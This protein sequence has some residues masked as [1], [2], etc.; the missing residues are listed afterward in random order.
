MRCAII[1]IGSNTVK[2]NVY[3]VT[4]PDNIKPVLSES[5]TLGLIGYIVG[6]ALSGPGVETLCKTVSDYLRLASD[7]A[8]DELRCVATASLRS[9]DNADEV[10]AELK[11]RSGCEVELISGENEAL[12]GLEGIK[13]NLGDEVRSG[14]MVDMGGGSTELVG[15]IDGRAVRAVSEPFGSLSLF[16][17]FVSGVLPE[18]SELRQLRSFVDSRMDGYDWLKNYGA[19]LYLVGGTGRLIGRLHYELIVR[20]SAATDVATD[21]TTGVTTDAASDAVPHAAPGTTVDAPTEYRSGYTFS[22]KELKALYGRFEKPS[23][24]DIRALIRIAPDR[25]H[26]L[27]P[28]LAALTRIAAACSADKLVICFSGIREGYIRNILLR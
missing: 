13:S 19:T 3:D 20:G 24:D 2:M 5:A 22:R 21:V 18:K 14:V 25:I 9:A 7:I 8:V 12:L 26:T 4:P 11:K 27:V 10:I 17:R 16:N 1:D 6:G 28:G 23:T 15:F